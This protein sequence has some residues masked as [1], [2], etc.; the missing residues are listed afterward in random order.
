MQPYVVGFQIGEQGFQAHG[1]GDFS[2]N[3]P[4]VH[5]VKLQRAHCREQIGAVYH[6]KPISG[7]Q[8]WNC[9]TCTMHGFIPR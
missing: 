2:L 6:R 7:L 3:K 9:Y 1:A 4:A 8:S 5:I